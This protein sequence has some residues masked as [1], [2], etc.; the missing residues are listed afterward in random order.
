MNRK[1][2]YFFSLLCTKSSI[3]IWN[4]KKFQQPVH[5]CKRKINRLAQDNFTRTTSP[6]KK[7]NVNNVVIFC[8]AHQIHILKFVLR[9]RVI[10]LFQ[11]TYTDRLYC[12]LFTCSSSIFENLLCWETTL[13]LGNENSFRDFCAVCD[14]NYSFKSVYT[15]EQ[16][17]LDY[18]LWATSDKV[19]EKSILQ[20][21]RYDWVSI[22]GSGWGE[23]WA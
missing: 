6:S 18:R 13:T 14:T 7:K 20:R 3:F 10:R 11:P 23:S 22:L 15:L 9:T 4:R 17:C 1:I 12:V 21:K 2:C 16:R 19:L 5:C 8:Q